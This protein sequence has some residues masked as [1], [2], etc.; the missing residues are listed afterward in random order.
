MK[1]F[2]QRRLHYY[3]EVSPQ[4][5][6]EAGAVTCD[7]KEPETRGCLSCR[8]KFV[9]L[10]HNRRAERSAD[11][12]TKHHSIVG[13]CQSRRKANLIKPYGSLSNRTYVCTPSYSSTRNTVKVSPS[14]HA[15]CTP[16]GRSPTQSPSAVGTQDLTARTVDGREGPGYVSGDSRGS[17]ESNVVAAISVSKAQIA[18]GLQL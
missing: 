17:L 9:H 11:T 13:I 4:R 14:R 12:Q 7:Y 10:G 16:T 3:S 18:L 6:S 1:F 2:E 5:L 15:S 8:R